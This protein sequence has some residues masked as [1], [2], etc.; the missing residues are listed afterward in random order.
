MRDISFVDVAS[1]HDCLNFFIGLALRD[2]L[3]RIGLLQDLKIKSCWE[4]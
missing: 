3:N 4:N 1:L 2:C